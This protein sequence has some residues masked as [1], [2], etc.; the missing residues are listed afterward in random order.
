MNEEMKNALNEEE[1]AN[2]AGGSEY[3]KNRIMAMVDHLVWIYEAGRPVE[4][5]DHE[6]N[7]LRYSFLVWYHAGIITF[8]EMKEC[9]AYLEQ[10]YPEIRAMFG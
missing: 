3:E 2:V 7:D 5:L 9:D 1:L 4:D 6:Y 10:R 8:D